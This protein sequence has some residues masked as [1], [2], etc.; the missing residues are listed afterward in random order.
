M[1]RPGVIAI[2]LSERRRCS[3]SSPARCVGGSPTRAGGFFLVSG[4]H[5]ALILSRLV[6]VIVLYSWIKGDLRGERQKQAPE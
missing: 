5:G 4:L 1:R 6:L 3:G 2:G